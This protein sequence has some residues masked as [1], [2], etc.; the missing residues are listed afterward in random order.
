M[1]TTF[2]CLDGTR[3]LDGATKQQKLLRESG[4]ARIGVSN[5]GKRTS[6]RYVFGQSQ[7]NIFDHHEML[8]D[9]GLLPTQV[10]R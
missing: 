10:G 1:P 6:L 9:L 2:A 5:D 8:T 3:H 4:F 7:V